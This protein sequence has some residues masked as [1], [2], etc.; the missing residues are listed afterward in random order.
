MP[1]GAMREGRQSAHVPMAGQEQG[2]RQ[3]LKMA[4]AGCARV[5][6]PIV[7]VSYPRLPCEGKLRPFRSCALLIFPW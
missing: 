4:K 1:T 7:L 5:A 3:G 6:F 2:S